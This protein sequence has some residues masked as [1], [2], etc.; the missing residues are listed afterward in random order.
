MSGFGFSASDIV[1]G[2][3]VASKGVNALRNEGGSKESYGEI[4]DG[5]VLRSKALKNLDRQAILAAT[6][7]PDISNDLHLTVEHLTRREE[8]ITKRLGKFE[9]DLGSTA[10]SC[11]RREIPRKLQWAFG[12][13]QD[14]RESH[15]RAAPGIDAALIQAITW[16]ACLYYH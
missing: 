8:K 12:G 7:S 16:A 5:L 14:F 9:K 3:K 6:I 15:A 13:E 2:V 4:S 10:S 1:N 11:K